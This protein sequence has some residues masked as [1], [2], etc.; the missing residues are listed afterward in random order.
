MFFVVS[1]FRR[2]TAGKEGEFLAA[3]DA[4]SE[5]MKGLQGC[6]GRQILRDEKMGILFALTTWDSREVFQA[7]G[8]QLMKYRGEQN[9]AGRDFSKFLEEPEELYFL[10]PVD[11]KPL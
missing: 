7:A 4:F 5:M 8:P 10:A 6:R 3:Q 1:I 2:V 11:S 9:R